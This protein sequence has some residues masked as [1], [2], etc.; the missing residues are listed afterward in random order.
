[1]RTKFAVDLVYARSE[2]QSGA[3]AVGGVSDPSDR[4]GVVLAIYLARSQE[5]CQELSTSS[6]ER[7]SVFVQGFL[8]AMQL[9]VGV[10]P[11]LSL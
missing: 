8:P 1:M 3:T 4:L 10:A 6:A 9:R 2:I 11:L 7:C 5:S